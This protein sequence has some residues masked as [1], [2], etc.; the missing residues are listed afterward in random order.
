MIEA[1]IAGSVE[2]SVPNA[3]GGA[4]SP[5]T[6]GTVEL[7]TVS[8]TIWRSR[9][10]LVAAVGSSI[11]GRTRRRSATVHELYEA[12]ISYGARSLM[13]R[14]P[15]HERRSGTLEEESVQASVAGTYVVNPVVSVDFIGSTSLRY[16]R[17]IAGI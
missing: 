17:G 12:L 2:I 6:A 4:A 15:P 13:N 1:R 7:T 3:W 9:I 8:H 16:R 11:G 5:G 10:Y 14:I